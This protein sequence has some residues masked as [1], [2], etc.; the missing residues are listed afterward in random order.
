MVAST[1]VDGALM[2]V[3]GH[4]DIDA[5]FYMGIKVDEDVGK[6]WVW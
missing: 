1:G 3:A 5:T 4:L 2:L 6:E